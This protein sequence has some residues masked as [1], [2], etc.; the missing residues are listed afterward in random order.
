M[1]CIVMS[2]TT[3]GFGLLPKVRV[4]GEGLEK[5]LCPVRSVL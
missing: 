2:C 5:G 1:N 3:D 4:Q